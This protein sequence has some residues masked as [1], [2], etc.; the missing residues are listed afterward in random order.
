M[1][2]NT[3]C[4][5]TVALSNC[6]LSSSFSGAALRGRPPGLFIPFIWRR[7]GQPCQDVCHPPTVFVSGFTGFFIAVRADTGAGFA[8]TG[9]TG[10]AAVG[11]DLVAV[12][13]AVGVFFGGGG[14]GEGGRRSTGLPGSG[15]G[16]NWE[17]ALRTYM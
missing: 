7:S 8:A 17:E 5:N 3:E 16:V 13:A 11:A 1:D 12:A 4:S 10:F 14:G 2:S 9:A 15:S 6:C